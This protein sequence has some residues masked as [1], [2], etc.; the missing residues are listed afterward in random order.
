MRRKKREHEKKTREEKNGNLEKEFG[1]A[2]EIVEQPKVA[3]FPFL[4][5][6]CSM[7]HVFFLLGVLLHAMSE[8]CRSMSDMSIDSTGEGF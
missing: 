7:C 3:R 2:L 5:H 6:K 8:M 1:E 4:R